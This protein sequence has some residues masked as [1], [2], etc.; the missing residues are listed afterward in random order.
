MGWCHY[1]FSCT[2]CWTVSRLSYPNNQTNPVEAVPPP[3]NSP[4]TIT[5]SLTL[6]LAMGF[7]MSLLI[8]SN[9]KQSRDMTGFIRYRLSFGEQRHNNTYVH[10]LELYLLIPCLIPGIGVGPGTPPYCIC[11]LLWPPNAASS[12]PPFRVILTPA[13]FL[14]GEE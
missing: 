6:D 1:F 2:L 11:H 10:G 14:R 7:I 9:S 4:I 12:R 13:Y 3:H 8:A 5:T